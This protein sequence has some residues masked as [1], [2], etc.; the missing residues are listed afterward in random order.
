ME[1]PSSI[2]VDSVNRWRFEADMRN[3]ADFIRRSARLS[4]QMF[5]SEDVLRQEP[6]LSYNQLITTAKDEKASVAV[7]KRAASVARNLEDADN[8]RMMEYLLQVNKT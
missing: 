2:S 3:A 7:R 8:L 4:G 5:H 6:Q 1:R